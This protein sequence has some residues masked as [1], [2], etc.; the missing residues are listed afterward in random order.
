MASSEHQFRELLARN[1]ARW[2][3][4]ARSYCGASERD[5][6][7]QEIMLQVWK[8]LDRFNYKS[9]IDTWAYRIALN[10]AFA[11]ARTHRK[12]TA[13][14]KRTTSDVEQIARGLESGAFETRV[15]EQF[16]ESLS[17]TDRA[18]MLLFLDDVSNPDA[19]EILGITEN[20]LRVRLHRIRR[21]F[22]DTY[23]DRRDNR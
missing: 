13:S 11:W 19:A 7:L 5:D 18:V 3:G 15:L 10:T 1:R 17:P 20:T 21:M 23:C 8:S 2:A 22:E 14:L 16:I 9:S 6:L 4:I 12:R